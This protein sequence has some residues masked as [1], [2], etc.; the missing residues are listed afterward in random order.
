MPMEDGSDPTVTLPP[1]GRLFDRYQPRNDPG[2]DY[3]RRRK[4][5][6]VL[7]PGGV[8]GCILHPTATGLAKRSDAGGRLRDRVAQSRR[9]RWPSVQASAEHAVG[10]NN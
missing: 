5:S 6:A 3:S 4:W 7:L 2:A 8:Y 10:I 9:H 1:S